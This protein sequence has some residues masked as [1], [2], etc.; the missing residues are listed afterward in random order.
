MSKRDRTWTE[1]KIAKYIKAGRGL[2]EGRHYKPWLTVQDVPANSRAH[3]IPGNKIGR[4]HHL[5]SDIER[6]YF[7][8]LDW[9]DEVIDIREQFPLER[10]LTTKIAEQKNIKHS[11]DVK[12]RTPLVMT[13]DFLITLRRDNKVF[14]IART[15]KP[16]EKLND[17]RV[18]EKFE[19]EREYWATK[20]VSWAIATERG[21][22]TVLCGNLEAI[23]SYLH[24]DEETQEVAGEFLRYLSKSKASTLSEAFREFEQMHFLESGAALL[25]F[26]HLLI[27]KTI[28]IN[29]SERINLHMKLEEIQ[30][31]TERE[32]I[33]RWAT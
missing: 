9:L 11:V 2:G 17:P 12:T 20:N 7:Y 14:H 13:T 15:I 18:I 16:A 21:M 28:S 32:H 25:C 22:P 1:E 26:K 33:T 29:L 19:I 3:R 31:R 8:I 10:E 4:T 27:A 23:R 5:M 6:D 24:V 30:I